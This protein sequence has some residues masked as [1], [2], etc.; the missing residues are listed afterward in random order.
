MARLGLLALPDDLLDLLAHRLPSRR[1]AIRDGV[2][3]QL[4]G[5][6]D[7]ERLAQDHRESALSYREPGRHWVQ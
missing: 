4:A 7:R 5:V 3:F 1:H 6:H 2:A